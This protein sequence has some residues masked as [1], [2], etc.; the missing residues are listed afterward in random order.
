MNGL[1]QK[2]V[3]IGGEGD[4]WFRRNKSLLSNKDINDKNEHNKKYYNENAE[5]LRRKR[6]ERYSRLKGRDQKTKRTIVQQNLVRE[7]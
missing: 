2:D 1:K 4:A 7:K 5:E 6:R 3:F